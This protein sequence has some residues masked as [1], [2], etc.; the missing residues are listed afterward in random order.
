[1]GV[2]VILFYRPPFR[3]DPNSRFQI[4]NLCWLEEKVLTVS[5]NDEALGDDD[6]YGKTMQS[7][8]LL[9][10]HKIYFIDILINLIS[11]C[12]KQVISQSEH[13]IKVT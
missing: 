4:L 8:G 13:K 9:Y 3:P 10:S 5:A 7:S 1:M 6:R 12:R 2:P 11:C